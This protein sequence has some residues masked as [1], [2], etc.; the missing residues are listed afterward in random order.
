MKAAPLKI[1]IMKKEIS[2]VVVIAAILSFIVWLVFY[3]EQMPFTKSETSCVVLISLC[4][5]AGLKAGWKAFRKRR[6]NPGQNDGSRGGSMMLLLLLLTVISGCGTF[7]GA[8][9]QPPA[10][11]TSENY[12]AAR[13]ASTA[14]TMD[15]YSSQNQSFGDSAQ[16]RNLREIDAAS[17][18]MAAAP[19]PPQITAR[20][21]LTPYESEEP[22]YG[23]Y[24]YLLFG[25]NTTDKGE[26]EKYLETI[27]VYLIMIDAVAD[28]ERY[29]SKAN[30]NITYL[31]LTEEPPSK[32]T[33]E[34]VLEHYDFARARV[35]LDKVKKGLINGPYIISVA[36]PLT[37][38]GIP[39]GHHLF[40]DLSIVPADIVQY[41][42][43]A[44][45]EQS[46]EEDFWEPRTA[47]QWL[48]RLRTSIAIAAIGIPNISDSL[49]EWLKWSD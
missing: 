17:A 37:T 8:F 45:M 14:A 38:S 25:V 33:P 18:S 32:P 28:V 12:D 5:A 27:T 34:W 10:S 44:F 7:N 39:A 22:G 4:V 23:L 49:K 19:E 21:F 40:Q 26:R 47:T 42:V 3:V 29:T 16:A 46:S 43:K 31:P 6:D 9:R 48:L 36:E 15:L 30:I 13:P 35:L 1:K 41:W 2:I 24:S 20:D 11:V